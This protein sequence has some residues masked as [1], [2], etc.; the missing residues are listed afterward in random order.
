MRTPLIA[1]NWKMYKKTAEAERLIEEL[2]GQVREVKDVEIV[3]CP[4]FTALATVADFINRNGGTIQTGAQNVYWEDE[5]AYTGEISAQMLVD[6]G[7]TYVIIGHSERRKHFHETDEMVNRKV[8]AALAAGLNPIVCVGEVLEEREA[9]KTDQVV[10]GQ[11]FKGLEG[12]KAEQVAGLVVAYEPVWAIG[13]GRTAEPRVAS[14]TIHNIRTIVGSSFSPQASDVVRILYG[15][16]VTP[17]NIASFMAEPDIDG[18]LVGG[19]SLKAE[20]FTKIA[21]YQKD[22]IVY[23]TR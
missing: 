16:S 5:G 18:A 1:G 21:M 10:A 14:E 19:A 9:G 17:D 4:P 13:T 3:V 2:A 7:V 6:I 22:G 20:T 11:I 12:L 23:Q 15:G 8:K